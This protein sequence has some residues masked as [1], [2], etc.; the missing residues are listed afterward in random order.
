MVSLKKILQVLFSHFTIWFMHITIPNWQ[1]FN[2]RPDL[3]AWYRMDA[4]I[5]DEPRLVE[6]E[7]RD[8]VVLLYIMGRVCEGRGSFQLID[9]HAERTTKLRLTDFLNALYRIRTHGFCQVS[10]EGPPPIDPTNQ[11]T[12]VYRPDKEGLY[13]L[14]PKRRGDHQKQKAFQ[15]IDRQITDQEKYEQ[16]KRAICNYASYCNAESKVGTEYV[17]QFAT[18]MGVWSEWI[19]RDPPL[20]SAAAL[21]NWEEIK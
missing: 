18:F 21:K 11:P 8:W 7:P 17:K 15:R 4:A 9:G 10:E 19:E 20:T 16:L 13:A 14:Y 1:K 12:N 3:R 6:L 2:P 5:L